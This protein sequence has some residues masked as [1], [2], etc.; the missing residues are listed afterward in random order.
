MTW[1]TVR[2]LKKYIWTFWTLIIKTAF[3]IKYSS[4]KPFD[5]HETFKKKKKLFHQWISCEA[6]LQEVTHVGVDV[7]IGRAAESVVLVSVPLEEGNMILTP[8]QITEH[9]FYLYFDW[10]TIASKSTC[11]STRASEIS[12]PCWKWTLS[13]KTQTKA[14]DYPDSII[15]WCFDS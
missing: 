15:S 10:L 14:L 1:S 3:T 11:S 2:I 4:Q 5:S 13:R 8:I 9:V 7:L 12:A 6:S